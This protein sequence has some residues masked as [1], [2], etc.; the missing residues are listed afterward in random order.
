MLYNDQRE[1]LIYDGAKKITQINKGSFPRA[2]VFF[3]PCAPLAHR[4]IGKM[5]YFGSVVRMYFDLP[6]RVILCDS[7]GIMERWSRGLSRR[8]PR[9]TSASASRVSVCT[10]M[11]GAQTYPTS[12]VAETPSGT[13]HWPAFSWGCYPS[14]RRQ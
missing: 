9:Y 1:F 7:C 3:F 10:G 5:V 8:Y 11:A 2:T 6:C 13:Y 14:N 12:D 4:L